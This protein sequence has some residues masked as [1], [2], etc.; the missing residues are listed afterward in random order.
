MLQKIE[1]LNKT[2]EKLMVEKTKAD[3]Q[4]EVWETK[5]KEGIK[6]YKEK[7]G[8]DL[9]GKTFAEMKAKLTKE[10]KAVEGKT[11]EEFEQAQKI[12]SLIQSGDIKGAWKL[13]GV[14][15][16]EQ[17]KVEEVVEET[18]AEKQ[19]EELQGVSSVVDE[20]DGISDDDFLGEDAQDGDF[21]VEEEDEEDGATDSFGSSFDEDDKVKEE[22]KEEVEE[23]AEEN[24]PKPMF[25]GISFEDDDDD[26][27]FIAQDTKE[28]DDD[29]DVDSD[30]GGFNNI[31]KGSKF[32]V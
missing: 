20:L 16:D 25:G 12:V 1:E 27:D 4:K 2:I 13:L 22:V 19:Q 28:D 23:K 29:Y 30:F 8:V 5:L 7:Y 11:Q 14:N 15:I 31:L 17:E 24:K 26:D 3:A 21:F 6:E 18:P 10:I 9:T 32:E